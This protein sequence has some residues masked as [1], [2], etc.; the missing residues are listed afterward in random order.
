ML[1]EMRDWLD[2]LACRAG[3]DAWPKGARQVAVIAAVAVLAVV[4]WRWGVAPG[5]VS[6]AEGRAPVAGGVASRES[7]GV[8]RPSAPASTT[9]HVV[10]AV[11]RPGLYSLAGTARVADAVNAAGGLLG[12]AD[13]S[14]INLARVVT[15]GEQIVVPVQG[16]GP[17][18]GAAGAGGATAGGVSGKSGGPVNLNTATAEQL[19]ALPGVGPA[20]A[21]KIVADRTENGPF[22]TVDDLLR[23]PG[24]GA[25]KLDALKDLVVAR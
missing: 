19:D 17:P 2:E 10:G 9:V 22:R 15:D 4:V 16:A 18:P 20:T 23:V 13:Q 14:G 25:K 24:I 21:A 8:G 7:T 3:V 12:N 11:R 6:A 1:R 5:G